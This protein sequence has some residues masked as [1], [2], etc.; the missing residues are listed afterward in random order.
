[1]LEF[2]ASILPGGWLVWLEA[3]L[4]IVGAAS[5]IAAATPTP[6]DDT[7]I[8][9][10]YRVLDCVALNIGHAKEEADRRYF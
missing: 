1:M 9:K 7:L 10:L 8:G 2:L 6:K 4:A 5:A 3:A